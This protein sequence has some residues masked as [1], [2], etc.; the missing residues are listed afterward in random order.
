MTSPQPAPGLVELMVPDGR[1]IFV[2][3][4]DDVS[5][6]PDVEGDVVQTLLDADGNDGDICEAVADY[7][8]TSGMTAR[9]FL[10]RESII[11]AI[12]DA[13]ADDAYGEN[14]RRRY[15]SDIAGRRPRKRRRIDPT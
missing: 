5:D 2:D 4:V 8:R 14:G 9:S 11:V 6:D 7:A 10:G 12:G 1:R 15:G 13:T 3:F